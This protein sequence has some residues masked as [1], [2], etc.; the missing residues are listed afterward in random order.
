M[1][2]EILALDSARTFDENGFLHVKS[3]HISKATVNPYRG[4]EIP[5]WRE[6]GLDAD[7]LYYALR[8][9]E[10]LKKSLPTWAGLPLQFEHHEESATDGARDTRVG[11]I[12][13]EITWHA[14]YIDAPLIVWEQKAIDA[15]KDGSCR[16]IS[17]SYW[18]DPDFTPGFYQGEPYDFVMRNIRGNHVALV[19]EGRAGRDVLVSDAQIQLTTK[20]EDIK[21]ARKLAK[22]ADPAV[23]AKEVKIGEMVEKAGQALQ[24]LHQEGPNGPKDK[25]A[26]APAEAPEAA[27]GSDLEAIK[28][29]YNLTDEALADIKAALTAAADEEPDE[30]AADEDDD[31]VG[32]ALEEAGLD[33][34]DEALRSAFMA[35]AKHAD[36]EETKPAPAGDDCDAAEDGDEDEPAPVVDEDEIVEKASDRALQRMAATMRRKERAAARVAPIL[37]RINPLTYDSAAAIYGHAL[38][39]AGVSLTGRRPSEYEGMFTGFAAAR[40]PRAARVQ[41]A[42]DAAH[43]SSLENVL[44]NIRLGD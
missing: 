19:P 43:G 32:D 25:P 35:G 22:D 21:M 40:F 3:S 24:Q 15:I 7:K 12:G 28:E 23:E 6:R 34:D 44:K 31:P 26:E 10:E 16:E 5:G 11:A 33:R 41:R 18:Y 9:P 13:T 8:D 30:T 1:N 42:S 37:G 36:G 38:R 27:D 29:K 2:K 20:E 14:P 4:S 17:C 39:K